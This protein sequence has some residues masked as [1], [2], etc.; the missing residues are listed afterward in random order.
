MLL[1]Q[2]KVKI[3]IWI[4]TIFNA[5][6]VQKVPRKELDIKRKRDENLVRKPQYMRKQLIITTLF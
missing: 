3:G 1:S 4:F 6:P 2:P 5:I